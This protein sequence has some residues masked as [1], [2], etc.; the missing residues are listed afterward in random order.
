LAPSA[1]TAAT[2]DL[3]SE[4]DNPLNAVLERC[5]KAWNRNY[6]LASISPKHE[7]LNNCDETN[8]DEIFARLQGAKAFRAAL[9]MLVG[10]EN[11]RDFIA[12]VT[13]AMLIE[14]LSTDECHELFEAAKIAMALLKTQ[15]KSQTPAV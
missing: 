1:A 3:Q 10:Y 12:C 6:E 11:I 7:G 2:E 13:Y 4:S 15:P 8:E 9:P 5:M 14:I